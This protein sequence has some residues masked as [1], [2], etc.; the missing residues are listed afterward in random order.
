MGQAAL[1]GRFGALWG[2]AR[3]WL[4]LGALLARGVG[5][6]ASFVIGRLAGASALGMYSAAVNTSGSVSL[7]GVGVLANATTVHAGEA[8]SSFSLRR[9]LLAYLG[10]IALALAVML[11]VL[12][13][14]LKAAGMFDQ[15]R[16]LAVAPVWLFA[17]SAAVIFGTLVTTAVT[18]LL[19][20]AGVH[21]ANARVQSFT[22]LLLMAL[23]AP[24]VYWGG[25]KGAL[26]FAAV[27]ACLPASLALALAWHRGA[28]TFIGDSQG[29]SAWAV[30]GAHLRASAPN[31]VALLSTAWVAWLC[32]IYLTQHA[33]GVAGVAAVAVAN[34]W[35]TIMLMPATSW[36]GVLIK[37]LMAHHRHGSRAVDWRVVGRMAR[38]NLL[39]TGGIA[40]VV[41]MAADLI[42]HAYGLVGLSLR[43]MIWINASAAALATVLAVPERV[44]VCQGRQGVWLCVS[45]VGLAFQWGVVWCFVGHALWVVPLAALVMQAVMLAL[46][47]GWLR[48]TATEGA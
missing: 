29:R 45:W 19:T 48:F 46:V 16:G 3:L 32:T 9:L 44:L 41:A 33:H 22:A 26:F 5:F 18:G 1:I 21:L 20:G 24:V 36:G 39:V 43:E 30:S 4:V 31:A 47:L 15:A 35:L 38:H 12:H 7:A 40:V 42:A 17:V 27:T 13:A 34:Q 14:A 37:E 6:I 10:W 11:P 2:N 28:A 25:L 8:G 23:A